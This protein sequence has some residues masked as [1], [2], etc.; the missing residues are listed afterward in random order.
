MYKDK[1]KLVFG[2]IYI[3]SGIILFLNVLLENTIISETIID[4]KMEQLVTGRDY[5]SKIELLENLPTAVYGSIMIV[6]LILCVLI[7]VFKIYESNKA[8]LA[9]N[10]LTIVTLILGMKGINFI[11]IAIQGILLIVTYV[12][13]E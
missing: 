2:I 8:I 11:I 10:I 1:K 3:L 5:G 4:L 12:K 6:C 9:L 7:F 13:R